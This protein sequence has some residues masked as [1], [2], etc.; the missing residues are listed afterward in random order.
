MVSPPIPSYAYHNA[1]QQLIADKNIAQGGALDQQSLL[2]LKRNMGKGDALFARGADVIQQSTARTH[3]T[4]HTKTQ[5]TKH[6]F[7]R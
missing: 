5:H 4:Q 7:I 1:L 2:V 6:S 3:N